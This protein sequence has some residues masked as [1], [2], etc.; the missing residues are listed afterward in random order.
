[1]SSFLAE[2]NNEVGKLVNTVTR[3]HVNNRFLLGIDGLSRS[4][5]TTFTAKLKEKLQQQQMDVVIFHIDD[6]IVER[7]KRY[8][9]GQEEWYEYYNLQWDINYLRDNLFDKVR[10][11]DEVELPFYS[12]E[13]DEQNIKTVLIPKECFIVVEGVFL[14]RE[15]WREFF[16]YM[17]Y[18]DCSKDE[19]F[20]REGVS[21]QRD[22]QK[23]KRRYWKAEEYY[24][25]TVKP[26]LN[27]DM[28]IVT[29]RA[30]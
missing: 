10:F 15:E 22:I 23:F 19:R 29:G 20:L 24:R 5:K 18:L 9:T 27:A 6:H 14:Q 3:L 21:T 13:S 4:G 8:G 17:V 25:E 26:L 2:E 16:D 30:N 1:M 12:S 28:I 7:K 11:H